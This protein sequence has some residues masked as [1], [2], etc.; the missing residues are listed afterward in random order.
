MKTNFLLKDKLKILHYIPVYAPAWK[1]GGPILSTSQLCE[2]LVKLGHDVEVFTT[3][4]GQD[5][6][7]IHPNSPIKRNGVKVTYFYYQYFFG[8]HSKD[9]RKTIDYRIHE[10]D[11]VHISGIW[12]PSSCYIASSS[13]KNN[14]PYVIST[15]GALGPYSWRRKSAKK[16]FY[17]LLR[18]RINIK[19]SSMIHYTTSQEKKECVWL[20][21]PDKS[22]VIPNGLDL[23][24][25]K[26]D[27]TKGISWRDSINVNKDEFVFLN[28]GR[29]HHKKGLDILPKCFS[30]LKDKPWKLVFIGNEED[31]TKSNLIK[32]F[33]SFNILKNIIFLPSI[34][35]S[36]L[37]GAYS[38]AN[39]F[40]LPSRHENFGNVVVESMA[41]GCPV[42]ISNK[43]GLHKELENIKF[44]W[45]MDRN[46]NSWANQLNQ[47]MVNEHPNELI[48]KSL[49]TFI[50]ENYSIK[51]TSSKM[52]TIY[53]DIL[54]NA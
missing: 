29:L 21:L 43:V 35:P 15:R 2:E 45:V 46:P 52:E 13:I 24:F 16:I 4:C 23:N 32:K 7:V 39:L 9:L 26:Y 49:T 40:L 51:N 1:Y 18:E 22:S 34:T 14:I 44:T 20:N 12:Q 36:E 27:K 47:I 3:S 28:V 5:E 10:F 53:K 31:K 8:I 50:E 25:W 48:R 17:Y 37:I 6:S 38:G 33:K 54:S 30:K 42:I 19:N 41:C 11:L